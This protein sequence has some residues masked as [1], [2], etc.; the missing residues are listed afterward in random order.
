M[1]IYHSKGLNER[2]FSA[3]QIL[4]NKPNRLVQKINELITKANN[5][6]S[7]FSTIVDQ[8]TDLL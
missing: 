4:V 3:L 6:T 8:T 5:S 1:R 7:N 2:K